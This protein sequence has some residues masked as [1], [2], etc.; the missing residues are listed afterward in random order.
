MRR[1]ILL[2]SLIIFSAAGFVPTPGTRGDSAAA[3]T[4]AQEGEPQTV[5]LTQKF[6][7]VG[8]RREGSHYILTLQNQY[9]KPINSYSIGVGAR[10][11]VT[12]DLTIGDLVIAPGETARVTVVASELRGPAGAFAKPIVV[13]GVTFEDGSDDG[14]HETISEIKGRRLGVSLQLKRIL[15]L[16]HA[17]M[18]SKGDGAATLRGLREQIQSLPESPDAGSSPFVTTGLTSAKQDLLLLLQ[19]LERDPSGLAQKLSDIKSKAGKRL[20]KLGTR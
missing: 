6:Q 2:L 8:L 16:L 11:K 19:E 18:N 9:A 14:D 17:A 4:A 7:I 3:T 13:L 5:N 12:T 15:P 10:S 1:T 20:D